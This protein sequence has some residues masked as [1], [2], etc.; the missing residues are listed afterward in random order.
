MQL[1]EFDAVPKEVDLIY[2]FPYS[3]ELCLFDSVLILFQW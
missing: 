2:D 1:W 3:R